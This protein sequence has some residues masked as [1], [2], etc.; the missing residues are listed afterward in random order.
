MRDFMELLRAKWS[1]GK[2][3]CVGLDTDHRLIPEWFRN[4]GRTPDDFAGVVLRYNMHIIDATKNL[5]CAYKPNSAFYEK[6]GPEGMR[7]L[8][9]TCEY[10]LATAPSVPI[11]LDVKRGDIGRST[12][13]Y[14]VG[15]FGEIAADAATVNPYMGEDAL[16]P[17]LECPSKGV[18]VLCRTSNP[19]AAEFQDRLVQPSTDEWIRWVETPKERVAL[20]KKVKELV[21]TGEGGPD[22]PYMPLYQLVAYRVSREWDHGHNCALVAGATAPEELAEIRQVAGDYLPLL[23]PGVGK[24]GGDV[25]AAVKA[26]VNSRGTG[27]IINSSSGIIFASDGEDFAEAAHQK[28][29]ELGEEINRY[30]SVLT[31]PA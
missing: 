11:I 18:I 22:V 25:E 27:I 29:R 19:G 24:Q 10:I 20:Q 28:T 21:D 6:L 30:R 14:M 17:F 1:E 2:F 26:G 15:A 16:R 31:P 12:E 23:I 13:G 4:I 8:Q 5:V 7:T 3:V 9:L